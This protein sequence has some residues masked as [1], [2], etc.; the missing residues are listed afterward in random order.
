MNNNV[1]GYFKTRKPALGVLVI[2][3]ILSILCF[4][5][6]G[7]IGSNTTTNKIETGENSV[8]VSYQSN[9]TYKDFE[10]V[11]IYSFTPSASGYYK[12]AADISDTIIVP[13]CIIHNKN[14][15]VYQG[16][17]SST[18]ISYPSTTVYL[19]KDTTYNFVFYQTN[20]SNDDGRKIS[21]YITLN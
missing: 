18:L 14:S 10:D 2:T 7:V 13:K 4:V 21:V 20:Y 17:I 11:K 9:E 12:I 5:L 3:L 15:N 19:L 1:I 8:I 16:E 6:A